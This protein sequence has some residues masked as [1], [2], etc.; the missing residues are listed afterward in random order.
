[1]NLG[2][3]PIGALVSL[4]LRGCRYAYVVTSTHNTVWE[5]MTNTVALF[6][7]DNARLYCDDAR[8]L[9]YELWEDDDAH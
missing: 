5:D 7:I 2:E 4:R 8:S 1:M 9:D 3:F 6:S